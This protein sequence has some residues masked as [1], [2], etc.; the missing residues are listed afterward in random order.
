MTVLSQLSSSLGQK[1]NGAN[2]ALAKGIAEAENNNAIQELIKNLKN[3]DKKIQADCI[4][5]LYETAYIK[6]DLIANYYVEFLELLSS[7]NNRLVWGGMIALATISDLK[8]K[9]LFESIEL[10]SNTVNKG[11]VITVDAGVE[12]YTNLNKYSEFQGKVENLLIDQLW[13]CPIKQL[14]KYMEKSTIL[15][16]E[17]NKEIYQKIINERKAECEKESQVKR[18]D[19]VLKLIEKL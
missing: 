13:K 9:E 10:I 12:I 2:I 14:P 16:N 19:K 1:G 7:K 11:S 18:L 8:S 6:P 4:K 5:T 15:I 17:K 3:K